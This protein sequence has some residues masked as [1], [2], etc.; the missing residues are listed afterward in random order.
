MKY[1]VSILVIVIAIVTGFWAYNHYALGLNVMGFPL[2][3]IE[4]QVFK[5][6]GKSYRYVN[7]KWVQFVPQESETERASSMMINPDVEKLKKEYEDTF[8]AS[9]IMN[10]R[11]NK[12]KRLAI[13]IKLAK[14]GIELTPYADKEGSKEIKVPKNFSIDNI[15]SKEKNGGCET[16]YCC[17]GSG[18]WW[19]R[20]YVCV[21]TEKGC[22]GCKTG[23][24]SQC[25]C[26]S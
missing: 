6:N 16:Q 2:N 23:N 25:Q 22:R 11:Q 8:K 1:F 4:G 9:S 7:G 12:L 15:F 5:K 10:V 21:D 20:S 3:P 26:T 17:N 13:N 24:C 18:L 19:C 14:Y